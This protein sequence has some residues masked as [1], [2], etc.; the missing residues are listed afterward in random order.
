M[1]PLH[2]LQHVFSDA[3]LTGQVEP[4][5]PYVQSGG[6]SV[7]QRLHVY[8]NNLHH[9]FREALRAVYPVVEKLVG[10]QF[11]NH[12]ADLYTRAYPST[13]G[14]LHQFGGHFHAFLA[15]F[16]P[17]AGLAYLPDTARLEWAIHEVFHAANHAPMPLHRLAEVAEAD[18]AKLGFILHP[19]C[20]LLASRFPTHLIWHLN[21]PQAQWGD[22][23]DIDS[24]GVLLLIR[25]RDFEVQLK[26]LTE[27]KFAMLQSLSARQTLDAAY[28]SALRA[29]PD[30]QLSDFLLEHVMD[31]TLVDFHIERYSESGTRQ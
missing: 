7:Q 17:A 2:E 15:D 22:T 20:R 12:A 23:L 18:H 19:A 24:G 31:Q 29:D 9:N 10:E 4:L 3:V 5:I 13:S 21:Q 8:F 11:F 16:S 26:P 28:E 1:P 25:R 6:A 27:G 14:D 30:F